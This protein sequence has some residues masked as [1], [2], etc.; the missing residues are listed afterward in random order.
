MITF[1][2]GFVNCFPT[3]QENADVPIVAGQ[4]PL[5][6]YCTICNRML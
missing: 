5:D 2:A 3:E 6:V 1:V 4:H